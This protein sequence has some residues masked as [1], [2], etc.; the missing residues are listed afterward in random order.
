[1]M[2]D[3]SLDNEHEPLPLD[4]VYCSPE[5]MTNLN[6]NGDEQSLDIFYKPYMHPE[7]ALTVGDK[8][9]TKEDYV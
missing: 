4:H 2:N 8:F 6:L 3:E 7:G 1:M 9:H 5:H